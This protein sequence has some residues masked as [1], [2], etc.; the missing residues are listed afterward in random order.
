MK[1]NLILLTALLALALPALPQGAR[2]KEQPGKIAEAP[3]AKEKAPAGKVN[4]TISQVVKEDANAKTIAEGRLIPVRFV[5]LCGSTNNAKL[6]ELEAKL[7][8]L[9][10][11]GKPTTVTKRL[12]DWT[13]NKPITSV[14]ELPMAKDVFAKSFTL[15]LVGKFTDGKFEQAVNAVKQGSFPVPNVVERKR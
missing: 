10:T 7:I 9:N 3:A 4:I 5:W 14:I 11:D 1:R 2:S 6:L 15:E 12:V 13:V 8:T